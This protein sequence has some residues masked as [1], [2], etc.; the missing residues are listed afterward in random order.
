V[1][2][3]MAQLA[4]DSGVDTD[5]ETARYEADHG[6]ARAAVRAAR[7]VHLA[8]DSIWTADALA[9]A[10]HAQGRDTQALS[11]AREATRL[12]TNDAMLWVHRGTIEQSLGLRSA[13]RNLRSG[14]S[15]DPGLS[16]WQRQQARTTLRAATR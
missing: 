11:Y 4:G 5:L 16:V 3:A 12:G 13:Q 14:L 2:E 7:A 9:W 8:A 15:M 10:L 1:L 6:S